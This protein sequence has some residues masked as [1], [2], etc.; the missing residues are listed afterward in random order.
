MMV[1]MNLGLAS[2]DIRDHS[3]TRSGP[4]AANSGGHASFLTVALR[5]VKNRRFPFG[6]LRGHPTTVP[7]ASF[8]TPASVVLIASNVASRFYKCV[9]IWRIN[10]FARLS[11]TIRLRPDLKPV[12][13]TEKN[14]ETHVRASK[15]SGALAFPR[16]GA[17]PPSM[18]LE[19]PVFIKC[20]SSW[21]GTTYHGRI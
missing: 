4:T 12:S 1:A 11:L 18:L 14:A 7:K 17:L 16:I 13:G 21:L 15:R 19:R 9:F 3:E 10:L 2:V 8:S 5:A 6:R 20:G